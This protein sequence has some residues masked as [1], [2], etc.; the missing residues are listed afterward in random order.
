MFRSL[1]V[2][3]RLALGF[4]LVV[5]LLVLISW[6]GLN[7][8][9]GMNQSLQDI[10]HDKWEKV[11]L[12]QTG[13]AGIN[14]IA[15][16][17]RD[18]T[19]A[20]AK[21]DQQAA[22]DRMLEARASV[23]KTWETLKP[24]IV[25]PEGRELF[26]QIIRSRTLYVSAQEEV[27]QLVDAGKMD[28]ARAFLVIKYRPVALAYR[29]DVNALVEFQLK[30]MQE[31]VLMAE[32]SYQ[33]ARSVVIGAAVLALILA[34]FVS[35][36]IIRSVTH[37]LGGEPEEAKAVVERIARG[38]LTAEIHVKA[39][40]TVS[41]MASTQTMQMNLRKMISELKLNAE[42]VASAALQMSTAAEQVAGATTYQSEAA[43]S[44]AATVEEM[45]ASINH[46]AVSARD[47]HSVT[48]ATGD[49]SKAGSRMIEDTVSGMRKILS[50]V[51]DA[52][53]TIQA[54]GDSSQK[55]SGIVQV[56]K[57]VAD[58]TNLLAL[59][60]A[61]EAARA[62]EQ[63]R[64]FSVVADEVRKLAERT[65]QATGEISSMIG[66]VQNSA[67]AAVGAMK[68]AVYRV[69]EGVNIAGKAAESMQDIT[70]GA[71]QVVA[72]VNDISSALRE[73][74]V[75]SNDISANVEKIAQMS[76]ENSAASNEVANAAQRLNALAAEMCKSVAVFKV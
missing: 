72:S 44:M 45:T 10:V 11:D 27:I 16:A 13:L 48:A 35:A 6:F 55:I 39:G 38:E 22:K 71:Q 32:E 53:Q 29:K 37:P 12:L 52:E 49:H 31:S 4:G 24:R 40:D 17:I 34:T 57:D 59:N 54:M 50:T 47:A 61:I 62:G 58:Q 30:L 19:L 2:A 20:T 42:E 64:G 36:W 63:G 68:D 51:S 21:S 75:A 7:R 33:W 43:S 3:G 46:V 28:E 76:E 8:L 23:G 74:S 66:A 9:S 25:L 15:I 14:E 5:A 67:H 73:Q 18:M 26:D 69:D 1:S 60:A 41:L 65:A 70:D 56:I